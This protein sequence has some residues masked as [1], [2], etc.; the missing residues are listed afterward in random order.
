MNTINDKINT[1]II[2]SYDSCYNCDISR[3]IN[4]IDDNK[5]IVNSGFLGACR[6]GHVE[7]TETIILHSPIELNDYLNETCEKGHLEIVKLLI[8][9]DRVSSIEKAFNI[10]C[11]E[12]YVDIV[13]LFLNIYEID[14]DMLS[15]GIMWAY[16]NYH[17]E[18]ALLLISLNNINIIGEGLYY[19][20]LQKKIGIIMV[21]FCKLELFTEIE[22]ISILNEGINGACLKNHNDLVKTLILAGA[23]N[24]SHINQLTKLDIK[25]F[26]LCKDPNCKFEDA[27]K[28][29]PF[30]TFLLC[31]KMKGR[32]YNF[33]TDLT[34]LVGNMLY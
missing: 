6:G 4:L 11:N 33:P 22:Q 5:F 9:Y 1:I 20:C 7:L 34:R 14:D 32:F 21:I 19:A 25:L 15:N 12:G 2:D 18:V 28:N 26:R 30:Y 8:K 27:L 17:D 16:D 29:D 3:V 23:N 31:T 10:A 13:Q 24:F